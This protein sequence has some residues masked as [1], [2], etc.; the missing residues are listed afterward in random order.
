[1][2]W[3]Q[4]C[5]HPNLRDLPFRMELNEIGQIVMSP[6]SLMHSLYSGEIGRLL[7]SIL[8][9]GRVLPECAVR[10]RKGTKVADVAW[11]S[12]ER[13]KKIRHEFDASIAPEICVEVLSESNTDKEMLTKRKLYF[14]SGAYEV[15]ICDQNGNMKF[16]NKTGQLKISELVPD[17]PKKIE[18]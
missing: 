1:M 8:E 18:I 16:Y 9:K 13:L 3:Q 17:F 7:I 6:V 5:E 15:W 11:V 2:N 12:S 14:E 10:T 4:V